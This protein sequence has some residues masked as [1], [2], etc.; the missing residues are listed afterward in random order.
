[1]ADT[2]WTAKNVR[3]AY[4][5]FYKERGH[6]FWP[7]SSTIPHD[8]PTLLFA[9]AGMNQYK[10]IFQGI[11]DPKSEMAKLKR[12]TNSQKCIRAGGKHNDL[13]DVGKD[14]YHHT[15]FEMLGNW[16][17][18][19]YFKQ[20]AIEW[21]YELLT[22]V[23][24]LDPERMYA[25]YFGGNEE[26]GLPADLEARDIWLGIGLPESR[27]LPFGMKDNFWEMGDTGPCGPCSE[28]HY[29]RIGGRDAAALVNADDPNVIEIWNLVFIQFNREADGSLKPLPMK[30]VDTGMGLE[31]VVSILQNKTSNYD[32]D[33]FM[34][35]FKAI[36]EKTGSPAYRGRLGADDTDDVDMAY[37]V[38]GDHIRTLCIALADGGLPGNAGRDYVLRRV[39]RR[40]IRYAT[41]KLNAEPGVFA[42]LHEIVADSLGHFFPELCKD[43]EHIKEVINEEEEQFLRTLA[44]GRRLL[45]RAAAKTDGDTLAGDVA[46]KLYDT[47]G[48]PAD[49]TEMMA[50]ERGLKIDKVA[51]EEARAQAIEAS[52]G[53]GKGAGETVALDVHAIAKLKEDGVAPTNDAIKYDYEDGDFK[54]AKAKVIAIHNAN[55]EFLDR[56]DDSVNN[57]IGLVLDCTSFYAESGGQ[58]YDTGFIT[59]SA[60]DNETEFAVEN[61]QVYGGYVLH[62]GTIGTGAL[63]LGDE[64]V[65]TIDTDR[66]KPVMNNHT[67]THVL[68]FALR[69][70]LGEADQKGSLVLADRLRFDF[71]YG[72]AMTAQQIAE[73]DKICKEV[74]DANKKVYKDFAPLAT[75]K[76]IHGLR[77][78][79]GETYPDPV[80]VVS[81][82]V[83]VADVVA[84]P[85]NKE[86]AT[87]SIEF[88]GG[89]HVVTT[90]D[91][92]DFATISEEAI[93]KGI[94]RV[95]CVTGKKARAARAVA[96]E[97]Q[98][99][100]DALKALT[101][102]QRMK[103]IVE[104]ISEI[105]QAVIP[106]ADKDRMREELKGLKKEC[107]NFDKKR[108]AAQAAEAEKAM[109]AA[110]EASPE[111]K[112]YILKLDVGANQ[113]AFQ[114]CF[115]LCKK[116]A[117]SAPVCLLSGDAE[118]SKC[119]VSAAVPKA[120]TGTIKANE[121]VDQAAA[122][123]EG[124][125]GGREMQAMC[126]GSNYAALEDAYNAC[127]AYAEK[128]L[129]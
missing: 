61:V 68:N 44:R 125:S 113:K 88:C 111:A 10:P 89:T 79:F 26:A 127:K 2:Q 36:E 116:Q 13:D 9:N 34:P 128:I 86:W 101:V 103:K 87:T 31:R 14:T 51:F 124:K 99:L 6:T 38:V 57:R 83:P 27:V 74:I 66:R 126:N 4:I 55:G 70:V 98:K 123:I 28:I 25:S 52:K 117:P 104:V 21:A 108:K 42:S 46:W 22:K 33:V 45:E 118:T 3:D 35:I 94:R 40:G 75:A 8:D 92:D 59:S 77:A 112:F 73:V 7:S 95:N 72:K 11:V 19:D 32:T 102:E 96:A 24:G 100:I 15:F 49:L 47:Y 97:K 18:G 80:R 48:F 62:V 63:A 37:R 90:G 71:T 115:N 41:E 105:D 60:G 54:S 106:Y 65:T 17:F 67:A 121:W 56:I 64:V 12:A 5:N 1:M 91:I 122:L 16:S 81:V 120:V 29:D 78:M 82:G 76:E 110:I 129:A 93:A 84:D 85:Y 69:K 50:N 114:G 43:P 39:L 20:E 30:H 119:M 53:A 58:I 107:D 23:Y 109:K